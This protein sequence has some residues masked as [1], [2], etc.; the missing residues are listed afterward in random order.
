MGLSES[1]LIARIQHCFPD[2]IGDDAAV[3]DNTTGNPWVITKDL[4]IE[5]VHFNRAYVPPDSLACKALQSNLSDLAAMGAVPKFILLGLSA[6]TTQ[7]DYIKAFVA[8]FFKQ[9]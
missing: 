6:P 8:A 4:L 7:S 3:I 5:G 1:D 9:V 2:Y